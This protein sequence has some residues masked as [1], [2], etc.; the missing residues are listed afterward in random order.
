MNLIVKSLFF[1]YL[2][3]EDD[4]ALELYHR[5]SAAEYELVRTNIEK[6]I[7][8]NYEK[9]ISG[10]GNINYRNDF[11]RICEIDLSKSA[12]YGQVIDHLRA[13]TFGDY[14]NAFYRDSDGRKIYIKIVLEKES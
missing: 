5:I 4:T 1:S 9:K 2:M 7:S 6:I 11:K 8:G 12:T 10:N 14:K 13:L 3:R